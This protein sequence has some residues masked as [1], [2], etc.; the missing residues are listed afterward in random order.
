MAAMLL[1]GSCFVPSSLV[2]FKKDTQGKPN[3]VRNPGFAPVAG[4]KN[5]LSNWTIV[6]DETESAESV[7]LDDSV[8]L[9]GTN[10]IRIDSNPYAIM[11][12]SDPFK[13]SR[14]GGYYI[15]VNALS[16][17]AKGEKIELRFFTY[18][19][20][21]KH[22]NRFKTTLKTS[23]E[24]QKANISAGFLDTRS[25]FGRVAIFIPPFLKGTIWI[26]DAGAWEVH[27]FKID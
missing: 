3:L 8:F 5:T 2:F 20:A 21:G 24:W 11:I 6:N 25:A 14:Y 7:N 1:L 15:K 18:N 19:A 26:D 22:I 17:E 9:E 16:S 10:S 23:T 12:V 27:S 4:T 13:V